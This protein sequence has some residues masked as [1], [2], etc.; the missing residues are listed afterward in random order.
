MIT[1]QD[2]SVT[3]RFKLDPVPFSGYLTAAVR[4]GCHQTIFVVKQIARR[5]ALIVI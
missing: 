3:L 2:F 4:N 1:I 5:K